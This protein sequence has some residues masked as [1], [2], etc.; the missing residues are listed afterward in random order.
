MNLEDVLKQRDAANNERVMANP[1]ARPVLDS[2]TSAGANEGRNALITGFLD[3]NNFFSEFLIEFFGGPVKEKIN[4]ERFLEL[5]KQYEIPIGEEDWRRFAENPYTEKQANIYWSQRRRKA[6]NNAYA[7]S[8]SGLNIAASFAGGM[9]PYAIDATVLR[10]AAAVSPVMKPLAGLM[11][12]NEA[13]GAASSAKLAVNALNR[14]ALKS[15]PVLADA[16]G[17]GV[18]YNFTEGVVNELINRATPQ[19]YMGHEYTE[20]DTYGNLL[21]SPLFGAG[22]GAAGGVFK[23][24]VAFKNPELYAAQQAASAMR[25]RPDAEAQLLK[26][27]YSKN[28]TI[29]AA[30]DIARLV[31]QLDSGEIKDIPGGDKGPYASQ[32]SEFLNWVAANTSDHAS[33]SPTRKKIESTLDA[34]TYKL[35]TESAKEYETYTSKKG[36]PPEQGGVRKIMKALYGVDVRFTKP[37]FLQERGLDGTM[38]WMSKNREVFVDGSLGRF[39]Q[40]AD[41]LWVAAHESLHTIETRSPELHRRIISGMQDF[42]VEAGG[43]GKLLGGNY[44][45]MDALAKRYGLSLTRHGL[46]FDPDNPKTGLGFNPYRRLSEFYADLFADSHLTSAFWEHLKK[47]DPASF[48]KMTKWVLDDLL[49]AE[50]R[51]RQLLRTGNL[52]Q[53]MKDIATNIAESLVQHRK[54]LVNSLRAKEI[55]GEEPYFSD[56]EYAHWLKDTD[57]DMSTDIGVKN[58]AI[59]YQ[60]KMSNLYRTAEAALNN[61]KSSY[62]S[63]RKLES[64]FDSLDETVPSWTEVVSTTAQPQIKTKQH[65]KNLNAS[66]KKKFI[67]EV[68]EKNKSNASVIERVKSA[69]L[70]QIYEKI[71]GQR[72]LPTTQVFYTWDEGKQQAFR[73]VLR[74]RHHRNPDYVA[75]KA[76]SSEDGVPTTI[77][78]EMEKV[79]ED[80]RYVTYK[81]AEALFED[82]I[83]QKSVGFFD[84][85]QGY[86]HDNFFRSI[87]DT[88]RA[89]L[90]ALGLDRTEDSK[91]LDKDAVEAV[92]EF[93]TE[94]LSDILNKDEVKAEYLRLSEAKEGTEF[95]EN[96]VISNQLHKAINEFL[97]NEEGYDFKKLEEETGQ[98]PVHLEFQLFLSERKKTKKRL[99]KVDYDEEGNPIYTKEEAPESIQ[100][101]ATRMADEKWEL[102]EKTV[103]A[104]QEIE[105]V[106]STIAMSLEKTIKDLTGNDYD[107][108]TIGH[109]KR[110]VQHAAEVLDHARNLD[111]LA[112]NLADVGWSV[113]EIEKLMGDLKQA[114]PDLR[115][116]EDEAKLVQMTEGELI[117]R[118]LRVDYTKEALKDVESLAKI[119]ALMDEVI[120]DL[121]GNAEN[122][123]RAYY[124][125]NPQAPIANQ[126]FNQNDVIANSTLLEMNSGDDAFDTIMFDS[127]QSHSPMSKM[128]GEDVQAVVNDSLQSDEPKAPSF[129]QKAKQAVGYT[130]EKASQK[131]KE[132]S[133][134]QESQADGPGQVLHQQDSFSI[135]PKVS[136]SV[137]ELN[138]K[139][140]AE[141]FDKIDKEMEAYQKQYSD[142]QK[143]KANKE[144]AG[145]APELPES[146]KEHK[147]LMDNDPAYRSFLD[148]RQHYL[149]AAEGLEILRNHKKLGDPSNVKNHNTF[150]ERV[151]QYLK[152]P[153]TGKETAEAVNAALRTLGS[154]ELWNTL[155]LY[156]RG[157]DPKAPFE[158]KEPKTWANEQINFAYQHWKKTV[159]SIDTYGKKDSYKALARLSSVHWD[160][161]PAGSGTLSGKIHTLASVAITDITNNANAK[162]YYNKTLADDFGYEVGKALL[163]KKVE[164]PQAKDLADKIREMQ[165][166]LGDKLRAA[167]YPLGRMYNYFPRAFDRRKLIKEGLEVFLLN[168][169]DGKV[170]DIPATMEKMGY[171]QWTPEDVKAVGEAIYKDLIER[172]YDM[173]DPFHLSENVDRRPNHRRWVMTPEGELHMNELLGIEPNPY[174]ASLKHIYRMSQWA[175]LVEE[176]GPQPLITMSKIVEALPQGSARR[177]TMQALFKTVSGELDTAVSDE[178]AGFTREY[179]RYQRMLLLPLSTI[180]AKVFDT[181]HTSA[182]FKSLT[183]KG[184]NIFNTMFGL[185]DTVTTK[186]LSKNSQVAKVLEGF[187][188]EAQDFIHQA[189]EIYRDGVNPVNPMDSFERGYWNVIGMVKH[190]RFQQAHINRMFS[191]AF[192]EY[193]QNV[194]DPR[195]FGMTEMLKKYG[196]TPEEMKYYVDKTI[197]QYTDS[198][199]NRHTLLNPRKIGHL[200]TISNGLAFR[201]ATMMMEE[202][203]GISMKPDAMSKFVA[204]LGAQPG[205][206]AHTVAKLTMPFLNIPTQ[207]ITSLYARMA[208]SYG[209]QGLFAS[210]KNG[211]S[212]GQLVFLSYA[213]S[214][215]AA[216]VVAMTI[217]DVLQGKDPT[218]ENIGKYSARMVTQTGMLP[219]LDTLFGGGR[220]QAGGPLASR[221]VGVAGKA[222]SGN[223]PGAAQGVMRDLIPGGSLVITTPAEALFRIAFDDALLN[224]N[225][226]AAN[227][228]AEPLNKEEE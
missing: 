176:F 82:K 177:A 102:T 112:E 105:K 217:K 25:G 153:K 48:E 197:G 12:L 170:T 119:R 216:A 31:K 103:F 52:D 186:E 58:A 173:R 222:L 76:D 27:L 53:T 130:A 137:A 24:G 23:V 110:T 13:G 73:K 30:M 188:R 39:K 149:K 92:D 28:E 156:Q 18:K 11:G 97:V 196:I 51:T 62:D 107:T 193:V 135:F 161:D 106:L 212:R 190:N 128:D 132:F 64:V 83:L 220:G 72:E 96:E 139:R 148:A 126:R 66:L 118:A 59:E 78:R 171:A 207:V 47:S 200:E 164:D 69:L 152:S 6:L 143:K 120:P 163:G 129:W 166:L 165:D 116:A 146:L 199:G 201:V 86:D 125:L 169:E 34:P 113:E 49:K 210:I 20:D 140:T 2:F 109:L 179:G 181:F 89:L 90:S 40:G 184:D 9:V 56:D 84:Q 162:G 134:K 127:A 191:K 10:L 100:A 15:I 111:E 71:P 50:A 81:D 74:T 122:L 70:G 225:N 157:S 26:I 136:K 154:L 42:I 178:L 98:A 141:N 138:I 182:Y 54:A 206:I 1:P 114:Y 214:S 187:S 155:R 167:G 198:F 215:L 208:N 142:W 168:F 213:A 7:G 63:Y 183:G 203:R 4:H 205:T 57:I 65:V 36:H 37:G 91:L 99:L 104:E 115:R 44:E 55:G 195:F 194:D 175:A 95:L 33:N 41:A 180:T 43:D 38:Y 228:L 14:N 79:V 150:A 159:D 93:L 67:K 77:S 45:R 224:L 117:L 80:S 101:G 151:A 174:Q 202:A 85:L 218:P 29:T 226:D 158:F 211:P 32:V 223:L 16:V 22:L 145:K 185:G 219:Y 68:E 75:S 123:V 94:V 5:S 21:I 61:Y 189:G 8:Q 160:K 144:E 87:S 147:D 133:I 209:D 60:R 124:G 19:D 35:V 17:Q 221:A 121:F 227:I 204:N 108:T 46:F 131:V 192:I 172:K 88:R 3:R